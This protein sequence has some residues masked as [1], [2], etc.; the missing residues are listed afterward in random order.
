M[1]LK[2]KII[3]ILLIVVGAWPFLLMIE[4]VS[5]IVEGWGIVEILTPGEIAYQIIVVLLGVLLLI[6][7]K[8][9]M[10]R[11]GR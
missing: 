1:G 3:G 7:L 9:R 8:P 4:Q 11:E 5:E 2:E 10:Q 6:S